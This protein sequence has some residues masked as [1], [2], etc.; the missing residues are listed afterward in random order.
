[1]STRWRA[2]RTYLL[3]RSLRD[4]GALRQALGAD[5]GK[6]QRQAPSRLAVLFIGTSRYIHFFPPFYFSLRGRFLPSTP[7]T[8]FVFTD[9]TRESFLTDKE[10]VV[11]WPVRHETFPRVNLLKFKFINQAKE[12]L[13]EYSHIVYIDADMHADDTTS[14]AELFCHDKPLFAVQHYNFV[15]KPAHSAF[16]H[17]QDSMAGV[18]KGEDLSVYW[19]ACFWGG[20]RDAFLE[21]VACLE[22]WTDIDLQRGIVAKWWDESFLNKYLAGRPNMVHTCPPSYAW[23]ARKPVPGRFRMKL[24][25]VDDNPEALREA[26]SIKAAIRQEARRG[27][28]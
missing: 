2:S 17:N 19:Q 16:E 6:A 13:Q 12:A 7:K 3:W 20:K 23:P 27:R 11:V 8:F 18:G 9:R 25:H 1:M 4:W 15:R 22:E 24:I 14:E 21:A 5:S 26:P 28:A 10:D